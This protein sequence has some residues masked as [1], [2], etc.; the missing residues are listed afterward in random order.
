MC[1]CAN[2]KNVSKTVGRLR[3]AE[4]SVRGM[5][6]FSNLD[7]KLPLVRPPP[8][9][10]RNGFGRTSH[11]QNNVVNNDNYARR[12]FGP[13]EWNAGAPVTAKNVEFYVFRPMHLIDRFFS[14][15][16]QLFPPPTTSVNG[17]FSRPV[18]CV[19][20]QMRASLDSETPKRA[21]FPARVYRNFTPGRSRWPANDKQ[22]I[23]T[24]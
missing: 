5:I 22:I 12:I 4:G 18:L 24:R 19:R 10:G 1:V 6:F 7:C 21:D 23:D 8:P 3:Y 20:R 17:H 13:L 11:R 16:G 15:N 14:P 9:A 2:R